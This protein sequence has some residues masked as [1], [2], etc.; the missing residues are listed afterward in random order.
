MMCAS[1]P[2]TLETDRLRLEPWSERHT[3]LLVRLSAE[4]EVM[5]YIGAGAVWTRPQAEQVAA[6]QRQHWKE[7]GF[8]WRPAREKSS[9]VLVGFIALN[10]AGEGTVGLDRDE[11]EIGWW[12]SPSV[13]G[14]G[15]AREGGLALCREAFATLG[16][17]SV[18]ARIQPDNG[19]SISVAQAIGLTH[20]FRTTG[21]AGEPV[22]VYRLRAARYGPDP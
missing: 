15:L 1:L 7:H 6:A 22:A 2:D 8:G 16:A 17:P 5:R 14:R 10:L 13:W 12:L 4:P 20:D 21:G 3:E 11:Y 19:R 18:V 9:G